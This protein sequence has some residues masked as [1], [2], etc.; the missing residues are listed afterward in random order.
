MKSELEAS[1]KRSKEFADRHRKDSP[2]FTQGEKVWL[3]RKNIKTT[4][5]CPKLDYTKLG[6]FEILQ[7]INPVAYKLKL[8][9]NYEIHPVFHASLLEKY[10]PSNIPG[11]HSE[12]PPPVEVEG[13]EA[14]EVEAIVD[15]YIK[16]RKFYYV[17]KWKGFPES[18]STPEPPENLRF[19]PDLVRDFHRR[20]PEKP[21]PRNQAP[22]SRRC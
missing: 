15:A 5:P 7:Q 19:C 4:R 1:Q 22:S 9:E 6:P 12:P 17:V 21:R 10:F 14:W 11:R 2:D 13:E 16:N 18:E 20:H 8:P 3:L